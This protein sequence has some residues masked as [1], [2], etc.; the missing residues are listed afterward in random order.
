M[1]SEKSF[2]LTLSGDSHI[3]A[4]ELWPDGDG[5]ENP[6]PEDVRKLINSSGGLGRVLSDWNLEDDFW[7]DVEVIEE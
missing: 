1:S 4:S 7:L 2:C 3:L 6:T 5:P